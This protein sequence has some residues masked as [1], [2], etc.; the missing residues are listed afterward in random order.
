[1]VDDLALAESSDQNERC[2]S[3][4]GGVARQLGTELVLNSLGTGE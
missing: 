4:S 3:S 2:K 1:M